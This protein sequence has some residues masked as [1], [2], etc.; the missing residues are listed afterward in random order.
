M[1]YIDKG[2]P[3]NTLLTGLSWGHEPF[4]EQRGKQDPWFSQNRLPVLLARERDT[5]PISGVVPLD[6]KPKQ[7]T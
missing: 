6:A 2:P 7:S 1:A 5:S 3:L 4:L